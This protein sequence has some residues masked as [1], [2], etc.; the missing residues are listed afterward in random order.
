MKGFASAAL[1]LSGEGGD[2]SGSR[3]TAESTRQGKLYKLPLQ[4]KPLKAFG[5]RLPDR[6]AFEQRTRCSPSTG[7]SW[8]CRAWTCTATP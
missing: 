8:R 3:A 5:L 2:V 6:T 4:W 1:H 7:R